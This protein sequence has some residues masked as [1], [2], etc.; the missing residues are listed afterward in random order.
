M[1]VAIQQ[2]TALVVLATSA[3]GFASYASNP[4]PF[5]PWSPTDTTNMAPCP[6]L[7]ALSNH[8]VLPRSNISASDLR[9]A[10][11]ALQCDSLIQ[12]ILSSDS[13]MALGH[14]GLL[15][16]ADLDVHGA[17]E[18]DASL[19]RQ[20]AALGDNTKLDPAL[21]SAFKAI[22]ADGKYITKS[23]LAAYR[24]VRAADSKAR[25]PSVRFGVREQVTAYVE[26]AV[27]FV[28][29]ADDSG[30]MRLDWL[31]MF[32]AH[33]KLPFEL[34]WTL[35]RISLARVLLVAGELRGSAFGAQ[36][37]AMIA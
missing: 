10:L 18:H 1:R 11:G 8:G 3:H 16:L 24:V 34:G 37:L 31:E 13:V 33:E 29:F 4:P 5:Q 26:A 17:I 22:S 21:L 35:R 12:R 2:A 7:N 14:G 27:L 23:E 20:D 36:V 32:F 28:A 19:T 30:A 9:S 6:M 15:T 25:N